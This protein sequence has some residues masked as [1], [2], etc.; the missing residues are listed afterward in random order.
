MEYKVVFDLVKGEPV[1][2]VDD[3]QGSRYGTFSSEEEAQRYADTLN[4]TT[5]GRDGQV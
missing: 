1:Y 4:R 2:Y 5:G 3:G